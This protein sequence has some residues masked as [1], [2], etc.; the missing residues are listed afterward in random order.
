MKDWLGNDSRSKTRVN[1][2]PY[3]HSVTHLTTVRLEYLLQAIIS[4]TAEE[5]YR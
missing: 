1:T 4:P 5:I 3:L 2:H